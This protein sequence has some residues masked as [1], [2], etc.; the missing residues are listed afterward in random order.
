MALSHPIRRVAVQADRPG[1]GYQRRLSC[2]V[3]KA[4]VKKAA[5]AT[6]LTPSQQQ[7]L[8]ANKGFPGRD[9]VTMIGGRQSA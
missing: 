5:V 4:L 8:L 6:G 1:V 7:A 9:Q 2:P 3:S